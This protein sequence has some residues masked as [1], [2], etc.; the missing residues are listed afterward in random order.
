MS[1]HTGL[2]A[3][4][5]FK[6]WIP[7]TTPVTMAEM[8]EVKR[9]VMAVGVRPVMQIDERTYT[10]LI[11]AVRWQERRNRLHASPMFRHMTRKQF[12]RKVINT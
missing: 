12:E 1:D 5:G 6:D 7:C 3:A 4:S 2:M 8:I 11:H 10:A 9:K